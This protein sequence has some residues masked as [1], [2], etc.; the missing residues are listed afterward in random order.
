M[1]MDVKPSQDFFKFVNGTWLKKTEIPADRTRWGSFD[2]LRKNTDND[3]LAILEEAA[4]SNKYKSDT[5]Q[6]KAINLYK[7]I[8]DTVARNKAG[9]N[10][11]KPYL[12]KINAVKNI[13]DLQK[14]MIEMA[15]YGG[16]GFLVLVL[17]PMQKIAIEMF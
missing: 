17:V 4:K 1:D 15:P 7:S 6:G 3:V 2:E 12:A 16:I 11:I 10:P 5:D 13:S 14:L 9:I 8:M